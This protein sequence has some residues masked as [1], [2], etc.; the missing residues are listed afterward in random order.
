MELL[1]L[2]NYFIA[3]MFAICYFYQIIYLVVALLFKPKKLNECKKHR[4]AVM[5]SAR[6]E[7]TVIGNLIKSIK[8]Q[9]YPQELVDIYL[10][11]D[12]CN[13]NTKEVAENNGAIVFERFNSIQRG[14]GYALK[15]LFKMVMEQYSY[16]NYDGYFIF[17]ADNLLDQNYIS[18][19]N[20]AYGSGQRVISS[21]RNSKNFGDNWVSAGYS[22]WFLREI[23]FLNKP[24]MILN[25]SCAVSG[26]GFLIH[27]DIIKKN[28]GWHH[29]LLS[30]D[31]EFSIDCIINGEKITYCE[32]A[33][34]YD[35]QPTLF[36]QSWSQRMRWS[37]GFLQVFYKYGKNLLKGLFKK[38]SFACFDMTMA[39]IPAIVFALIGFVVNT[40]MGLF[41]ILT[42]DK[43][44]L[45]LLQSNVESFVNAYIVM[46]AAG[47]ITEIT[48]WN[49]IHASTYKKIKYLFTFP[50]FMFSYVPI[51]VIAVFAKV[52]W[53]PIKHC[54]SLTIEEVLKE[55]I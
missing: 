30:E 53:K 12:N 55:H 47:L 16:K 31:I 1:K 41:C 14:K 29:Y 50:I 21:Y 5:I 43:G 6:N 33:I 27:K 49:R 34:L 40:L 48:E 25:T 3:F 18:E 2:I 45:T 38:N 15:Y 11:A 4:F 42:L 7:E 46:F 13:D 28:N 35:E 8:N 44:I 26:T 36:T 17:D 51:S 52:E 54:R 9:N 22:L 23:N 32:N 10:V 39:I 37:K 19:M 24:R 20:K